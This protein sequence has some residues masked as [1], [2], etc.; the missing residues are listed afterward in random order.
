VKFN[1]LPA[2]CAVL[3]QIR[4]RV[5]RDLAKP[6]MPR[7]KALAAI[8]KLLETTN[9]RI[10]NAEYAKNNDSSGL[11]T[12]RDE[13]VEF[14]G[15][16]ALFRFRGKSGQE[17]EVELNDRRLARIVQQCH[18]LPG[19]DLFQYVDEDGEVCKI[20]SADVNQYLK[21]ISGQELTAKEFR[22][23]AGT[24]LMARALAE[25]GGFESETEAKKKVAEAV[26]SVARKLG[27]KPATC[28]AY[29]VHPCVIEAYLGRAAPEG[30]KVKAP[31]ALSEEEARVL[32]LIERMGAGKPGKRAA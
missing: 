11:T 1:R 30:V 4:R 3:P 10:G 9:I 27:N 7:E 23:W 6:G 31:A 32:A 22:T 28:R 20:G 25:A 15:G 21:E 29:Y 19:Y 16:K 8:V 14:N 5:E 2:F 12:L 26:K 18:D 24:V 13:H 17:H